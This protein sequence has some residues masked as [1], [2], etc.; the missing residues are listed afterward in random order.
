MGNT[1]IDFVCL[2]VP[3]PGRTTFDD[4]AN[5]YFVPGQID[6]LEDLGQQLSRRPYEGKALTVLFISRALSDEHQT[7]IR[8]ARTKNDLC[9]AFAQAATLASC[10]LFFNLVERLRRAVSNVVNRVQEFTR[11]WQGGKSKPFQVSK[12]SGKIMNDL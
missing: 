6:R 4:I 1:G 2:R 12:V 3:V 11:Q 9:S 10:H 7:G 8:I 5:I